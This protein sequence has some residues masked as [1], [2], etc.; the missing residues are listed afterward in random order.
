MKVDAELWTA[1]LIVEVINIGSGTETKI[2][3]LAALIAKIIKRNSSLIRISQEF[4]PTTLA[5]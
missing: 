2:R 3:D 1:W 4:V 5:G